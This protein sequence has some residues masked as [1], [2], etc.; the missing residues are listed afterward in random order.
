MAT[1]HPKH[2]LMIEIEYA[3]DL[4]QSTVH[5]MIASLA[6]GEGVVKVSGM[7]LCDNMVTYRDQHVPAPW[8]SVEVG[9]ESS[10]IQRPTV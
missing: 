9:K 5:A 8:E 6:D 7:R 4:P 3:D 1:E 2:T 10:V